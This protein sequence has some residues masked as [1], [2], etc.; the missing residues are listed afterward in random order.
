MNELKKYF[1]HAY[2]AED[3][4]SLIIALVIYALIGFA[5]GLV[6]GLLSAIPI[7]GIIF[8]VLGWIVEL[9]TIAGIILSILVF[10]KIVK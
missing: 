9:Y 10:L 7:I 2:K 8:K 1:P 6:L 4:K 3:V 5:L